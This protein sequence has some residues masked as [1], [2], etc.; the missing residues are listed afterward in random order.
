MHL[1]RR[2]CS[3]GLFFLCIYFRYTFI[4]LPLDFFAVLLDNKEEQYSAR[5]LRTEYKIYNAHNFEEEFI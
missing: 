5:S 4:N 3:P 1:A 2:A